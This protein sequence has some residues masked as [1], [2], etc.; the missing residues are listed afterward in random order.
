M[1]VNV[2]HKSYWK[3]DDRCTYRLDDLVDQLFS[4]V[5]LLFRIGHDQAVQVLILVACVSSIGFSFAFLYGAFAANS[6]LGKGLVFHLL[7]RV[8]T[9]SNEETNC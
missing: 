2:S 9:R 7:E 8:A 1:F 3:G 5:D 4:L 6:D